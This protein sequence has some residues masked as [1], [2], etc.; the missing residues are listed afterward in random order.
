M[1]VQIGVLTARTRNLILQVLLF[2]GLRQFHRSSFVQTVGDEGAEQTQDQDCPIRVRRRPSQLCAKYGPKGPVTSLLLDGK[3]DSFR[4]GP[5]HKPVLVIA[6]CFCDLWPNCS[7]CPF[8]ASQ[9]K[10]LEDHVLVFR[11]FTPARSAHLDVR[12]Q[13]V[14]LLPRKLPSGG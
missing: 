14:V 5:G 2:S 13:N 8:R 6:C 1:L 3:W 10:L 7:L 12:F 11:K 9:G 4:F